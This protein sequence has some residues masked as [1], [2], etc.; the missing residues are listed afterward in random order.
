MTSPIL[1]TAD[2]AVTITQDN[3]AVTTV[4]PVTQFPLAKNGIS[5]AN[6]L[7]TQTDFNTVTTPGF[8]YTIDALSTNAPTTAHLWYLNVV[9]DGGNPTTYL[10]QEA[11]TLDS[12]GS[13]YMRTM[14]NGSWG[15][16]Q[17]AVLLDAGGRLPAVDGSQLTN[18]SL[19]AAPT[20]QNYI[21]GLT[22]S[23]AGSSSTFSVAAGVAND[24][25]NVTS[26]MLASTMSKTT[27]TWSSGTGNGALDTGAIANSTWYKVFLIYNPTSVTIDILISLSLT[28][29][30]PTGYTL[31]RRIGFMKTNGSAQWTS[32]TQIGDEFIWAARTTDVNASG[33]STSSVLAN[34]TVP[35]GIQVNALFFARVDFVTNAVAFLI[36]SPDETDQT[37]TSTVASLI[38]SS[39]NTTGSGQFNVRTN[40]SGQV[41]VRASN[42]GPNYSIGTYGWID[43]RGKL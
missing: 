14:I 15:S 32:F 10:I 30:L 37:P 16:W 31:Y 5:I 43:R 27:S 8:F 3:P 28:P 25:T 35:T 2:P 26:M 39:S 13:P 1:I 38:C 34:L 12:S 11:M 17:Q 20:F 41:R 42:T 40:T 6:P 29:L 4:V 22:L 9:V 19:N 21:S 33:V 24:S 23:T 7:A 36:T 18:V